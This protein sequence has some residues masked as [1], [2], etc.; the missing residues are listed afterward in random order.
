MD[1]NTLNHLPIDDASS[2]QLEACP[3]SA[4][5]GIRLTHCDI[6][7]SLLAQGEAALLK[8]DLS[9]GLE[10]FDS[11]LKLDSANP[12]IYYAQ[13]LSLFEYGND[14]GH[15]KALPLASKKFK[16]ATT[17]DPHYFEA[18][19]AWGSLL[20]TLGLN[21]EEHHYF[22]EAQ[23]K[24][25]K[26]VTLSENQGRDALSELYWDLG[27]VF[28]H[29]AQHSGEALD[30]HQAIEAFQLAHSFEEKL[31]SDFWNDFGHACLKFGSQINDMRFYVKA[32][33]CLKTAVSL[34]ANAFESWCLLA[35]ALQKLYF[36]THDEDHFSQANDCLASAAQIQPQDS[37]VWLN[38]AKFLCDSAKRTADVKRLRLCIEK[39]HRAFSLDS[40]D[41]MILA[42]W[43]E[44][45]SLLGNYTE[46]LDLI[47]DAQ[48]KISQAVELESEDPEIWYSYGICMQAFGHYFDD[49]DYYYQ[50]IEKFQTGLSIDRTCYRHWHAIG[51]TYSLLG[52]LEN[53]PENLELSL[54]FFQ[55]AVDLHSS[56]YYLF[57][58]AAALS[59]LGEMTHEQSWLEESSTQ[60][61]RLLGLQKNAVYL[62][63]DWLFQY[64][65]TLDSLGDFHEEEF[66]Y[67][68]A[69]EILS[70]VLMIDP[71]FHLVHH[72]LGLALSHLGELTSESDHFYRA[73]HHYR[74]A[75]KND[76]ENDA[77]LLDWATTLINI[78]THSHDSSESDQFFRD[79]EHKFQIAMRLGN[80][81]T[82]YH[83]ACLYSLQGQCEK[84]MRCLEKAR[85]YDAL[86][87]T[88]EMLQ[89]EW[90]DNIRSTA[91]F[92]GFLAQLDH[93]RNFQ[94]E[95]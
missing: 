75:M 41:P 3:A 24:L 89:D 20:C 5:K 19:Q 21:T 83:L 95:C 17:L 12:K 4:E 64:A 87:T 56:T 7:D 86:P 32:I 48:N 40:S 44:A 11:A 35:D 25:N 8:G 51:W 50:A 53:N 23:E 58:Y 93:R 42:I 60:F 18:W 14:E 15:E 33:N 39:C 47:Y 91:D 54:R 88:D 2:V 85:D 37:E 30:W 28:A 29:L 1:Q 55:K 16:A 6:A 61:E 65:C 80:L 34:D 81:Q 59:K 52:D 22:K 46:R 70:H 68:R 92:Q 90:L 45:L 84:G 36:H 49:S 82:Y 13:G 74:L 63:P 57:D 71:D 27:I 9:K 76:E 38:W 73:I 78:A 79:A 69:I 26:A 62:H 67:L 66:Y 43:G 77:V 31:P 72:R 94:E 10:C